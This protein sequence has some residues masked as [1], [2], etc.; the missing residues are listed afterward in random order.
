MAPK[1]EPRWERIALQFTPEQY[2]YLRRRSYDERLPIAA[3]VRDLVEIRR[4][5]DEER[6]AREDD[7]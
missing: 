3:L 7:R 1:V 5:R 4:R 2:E 6:A